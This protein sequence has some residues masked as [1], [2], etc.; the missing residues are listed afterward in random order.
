MSPLP[1]FQYIF[2]FFP[3]FCPMRGATAGLLYVAP[4]RGSKIP[5]TNAS[6]LLDKLRFSVHVYAY[7]LNKNPIP[8]Q[9]RYGVVW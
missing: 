4:H 3:G 8:S 5:L 7:R 1:G 2:H 9:R 6:H